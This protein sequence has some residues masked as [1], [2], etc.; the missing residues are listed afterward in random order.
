MNFGLPA[1]NFSLPA[2]NFS[3]PAMNFSLPAMNFS[4]P[5]MNFSLLA[6]NFGLPAM[7]FSLP[8]MKLSLPAM[9]AD[10]PVREAH[11]PVREAHLPDMKLCLPTP[12]FSP[13]SSLPHLPDLLVLSSSLPPPISPRSPLLIL[14]LWRP[15]GSQRPQP[16]G[17]RMTRNSPSAGPVNGHSDRSCVLVVSHLC[18]SGFSPRASLMAR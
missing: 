3:L 5:A 11:L 2:M 17:G 15:P 4:L 14:P 9:K 8:A 6:M 13:F 12:S 7:N 10:L 16:S 1:M 18:C